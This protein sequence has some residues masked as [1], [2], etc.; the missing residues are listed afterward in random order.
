MPT[1]SFPPDGGANDFNSAMLLVEEEGIGFLHE[2]RFDEAEEKFRNIEEFALAAGDESWTASALSGLGVV[3]AARGDLAAAEKTHLEAIAIDERLGNVEGLARDYSNLASALAE[4]GELDE[5]EALF[6]KSL[7]SCRKAGLTNV[8]AGVYGNLGIIYKTRGDFDS[9]EKMYLGA[10][11]LHEEF[12]CK[13]GIACQCGGL[14]G[15]Y[16][17]RK[18]FVSA[19]TM[20]ARALALDQELG[21]TRNLASDHYNFGVLHR[22]LGENE[23]AVEMFKMAL[24]LYRRVGDK[25]MIA[26]ALEVLEKLGKAPS[27]KTDVFV[28]DEDLENEGSEDEGLEDEGAKRSTEAAVPKKSAFTRPEGPPVVNTNKFPFEIEAEQKRLED[29]ERPKLFSADIFGRWLENFFDGLPAPHKTRP[30]RPG[31]ITVDF[32][33]PFETLLGALALGCLAVSLFFFW[34]GFLGNL[35]LRG[36]TSPPDPGLIVYAILAALLGAV[37]IIA[38]LYTDNYYFIDKAEKNIYYQFRLFSFSFVK[39]FLYGG[40]VEG[41]GVSGR[42]ARNADKFEG[43]KKFRPDC[44]DG[45]EYCV[46][47]IDKNGRAIKFGDFSHGGPFNSNSR[48][49]C[50]AEAVQCRSF[51]NPGRSSLFVDMSSGAP[52]V[53]FGSENAPLKSLFTAND[54]VVFLV[55]L[56]A[57]SIL[58]YAAF[59]R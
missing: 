28:E 49:A 46:F 4:R 1:S 36:F 54:V 18:D 44:E 55:F 9:A 26:A 30:E 11:A 59:G 47:I 27:K 33:T 15:L 6:K 50:L 34:K 7:D 42:P 10:L 14:G 38:R 45:W 39:L 48:A 21:L 12:G 56:A 43:R 17:D 8:L 23:K 24:E 29:S 53:R 13:E 58:I 32:N 40:A 16:L 25:K 35:S 19:R 5:A 3:F 41:F 52:R 57:L 20:L 31:T 2:G 37:S 51:E 22:A